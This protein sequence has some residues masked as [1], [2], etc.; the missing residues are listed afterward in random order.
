M[1]RDGYFTGDPEDFVFHAPPRELLAQ[2]VRH[3][4]GDLTIVNHLGEKTRLDFRSDLWREYSRWLADAGSN[5]P[6]RSPTTA[7]A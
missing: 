7:T 1:S 5:R 4:D 6:T 2:A 3:E